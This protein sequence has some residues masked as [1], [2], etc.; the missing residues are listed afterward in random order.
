MSTL[1]ILRGTDGRVLARTLALFLIVK[2]FAVALGSG[3]SLAAMLEG[4]SVCTPAGVASPAGSDHGGRDQTALCAFSCQ[5]S[6]SA[7]SPAAPPCAPEPTRL[8]AAGVSA[9]PIDRPAVAM[10][11]RGKGPRGPPVLA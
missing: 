10:P 2:L 3:V 4:G 6:L 1:A 11:W 7:A 5:A 8:F 9:E